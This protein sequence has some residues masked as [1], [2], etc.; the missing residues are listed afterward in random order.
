MLPKFQVRRIANTQANKALEQKA[1]EHKSPKKN[2]QDKSA[3]APR[4]TPSDAHSGGAEPDEDDEEEE[5][6]TSDTGEAKD[7]DIS[8]AT[9]EG[10]ETEPKNKTDAEED[11]AEVIAE[12]PGDGEDEG[13][14]AAAEGTNNTTGNGGDEEDIAAAEGTDGPKD[15]APDPTND[16]D[17]D[18]AKDGVIT[19]GHEDNNGEA[20]IP[21][22]EVTGT[23]DMLLAPT[24]NA[25]VL[26]RQQ[27]G[28]QELLHRQRNQP[29]LHPGKRPAGN[30][31]SEA[32]IA[33]NL[34]YASNELAEATA[35]ATAGNSGQQSS[36][37]GKGG[38]GGNA[39]KGGSNQN[40]KGRGGGKGKGGNPNQPPTTNATQKA[41]TSA[42]GTNEVV[43]PAT[44]DTAK[45]AA[46]PTGPNE[47]VS[48]AKRAA[49]L[50]GPTQ[51]V[52][53]HTDAATQASIADYTET[54]RQAKQ[55]AA[56]EAAEEADKAAD[57]EGKFHEAVAQLRDASTVHDMVVAYASEPKLV[58]IA[59]KVASLNAAFTK[60]CQETQLAR[61]KMEAT[62]ES[63]RKRKATQTVNR[64]GDTKQ[65]CT[66]EYEAVDNG[67]SGFTPAHQCIG[68]CRITHRMHLRNLADPDNFGLPSK[69]PK[70][71]AELKALREAL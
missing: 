1:K 25:E 17:A 57:E 36:T 61:G 5:I 51:L 69:C 42:T 13:N 8:N 18:E 66:Y 52:G 9:G 71:A 50:T 38:K 68:V 49:P 44:G 59:D 7:E 31:V 16:K 48:T 27:A 6:P 70:H 29:L 33:H 26:L 23:P 39:G 30:N 41:A 14:T 54:Q 10:E 58:G 28:H 11:N 60:N 46:P 45:R 3:A 2:D 53:H 12:A 20:D 22:I 43:A 34:T 19:A 63:N 62:N 47:N 67:P 56:Q 35:K 32:T 65:R 4:T 37:A 64:R 15:D 24:P 21:Y 40:G 55:A